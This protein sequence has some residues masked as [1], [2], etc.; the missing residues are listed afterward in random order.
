MI[1]FGTVLGQLSGG[2][3][4][5]IRLL[6]QPPVPLPTPIAVD[7]PIDAA[8]VKGRADSV[9]LLSDAWVDAPG[10]GDVN[11]TD[12]TLAPYAGYTVVSTTINVAADYGPAPFY[13]NRCVLAFSFNGIAN[14]N[15]GPP[16]LVTLSSGLQVWLQPAAGVITSSA[17][18]TMQG[19]VVNRRVGVQNPRPSP[20]GFGGEAFGDPMGGGGGL[21]LVRAIAV[22]GQLVR[23]V[24][25][26]APKTK[27]SA[28][29]NDGLNGANYD[30]AI[31]TGTGTKPLCVSTASVIQF[32]AFG[33]LNAG[34]VGID[35]QTDRP[36]VVGLSYVLTVTP[37]M[38]AFDGD[39]M[40]FPYIQPFVGA[41]R[42]ARAR[43]NRIKQGIIDFASGN[44][45]LT[46]TNGDIDTVTGIP[47]T[48]MRC[49]RRTLTMRNA[50]AHLPGYGS[51]FQPKA[52]LS[53]NRIGAIQTDLRQQLR[54]EPDVQDASV[55][56]TL[57]AR[58]LALIDERVQTKK[59]QSFSFS[60][61][62]A[63]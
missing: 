14:N 31:T 3:G 53:Q 32:P 34:E 16:Q 12:A 19:S 46:A 39:T 49:L 54:Q 9:A 44:N 48:K 42:P 62:T 23:A 47:S 13:P 30:V 5:T 61:K 6:V 20:G 21:H 35:V 58:G 29:N 1:I 50:F 59:N 18:A 45:G 57:D 8:T 38:I 27:S 4:N 22:A 36:L 41:T 60:I 40:G 51:S 25:N 26:K 10:H 43:Q 17:F 2:G 24:F 33:L 63:T 11:L 52:P 7:V 55:Q 56:V 28:A 15:S 37:R